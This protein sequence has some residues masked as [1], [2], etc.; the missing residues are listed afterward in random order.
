MSSY[1]TSI[2]PSNKKLFALEKLDDDLDFNTDDIQAKLKGDKKMAGLKLGPL[3]KKENVTHGVSTKKKGSKKQKPQDAKEEK[4]EE[5]A[6]DQYDPETKIVFDI[7]IRNAFSQIQAEPPVF[8]KDVEA[9]IV[10]VEKKK[11]EFEKKVNEKASEIANLRKNAEESVP[12][13]TELKE[14]FKDAPLKEKGDK[15]THG[16]DGRRGTRGGRATRGADRE[17]GTD[18]S[19]WH[20]A[21]ERHPKREGNQEKPEDAEELY[22]EEDSFEAQ[23]KRSEKA[24]HVPSKAKISETDFPKL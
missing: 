7:Q 17:R 20:G 2:L 6:D 9:S 13:L 4:K 3:V 18:N 14:R 5:P 11:A 16:R 15:G 24:K 21:R 22:Q 10:A 8:N 19:N 23:K 1:L 12:S